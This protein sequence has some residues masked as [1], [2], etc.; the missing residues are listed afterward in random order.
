MDGD[1]L[2]REIDELVESA[3]SWLD[4][5][6]RF[7]IEAEHIDRTQRLCGHRGRHRAPSRSC[8]RP[9]GQPGGEDQDESPLIEMSA[10]NR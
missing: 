2:Q 1:D 9:C 4:E 10:R 5:I 8:Q 3:K 7:S 6:G